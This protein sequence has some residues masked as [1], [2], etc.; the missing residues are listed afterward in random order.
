MKKY[1]VVILNYNTSHDAMHAAET[2]KNCAIISDYSICIVDNCSS[3]KEKKILKSRN[4][5]NTY[6]YFL[7]KNRGYAAGNNAGIKFM[8]SHERYKYIVIMNPDVEVI[9]NGTIESIIDLIEN[10]SN[11]VIGGQPLVWTQSLGGKKEEQ[12]NIR[13]VYSKWDC[14]IQGSYLLRHLLVKRTKD[15][16]YRGC[17]PYKKNMYY[18]V[19]SG[20][21]FIVNSDA[22]KQI[23]YFDEK[24]FLYFEEM[25]LGYKFKC[26]NQKFI[27]VPK[28]YVIHEQGKSTKSTARRV[29]KSSNKYDIESVSIYLEK[30]LN[31][32]K[33]FIKIYQ[34]ERRI[35]YFF[36]RIAYLIFDL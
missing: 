33:I 7:D 19:P 29:S 36:K 28:Y 24:T 13:R 35:D 23:G 14:F 6:I 16:A 22:F 32:S 26:K 20:A 25:I 34:L 1:L 8:T 10:D 31:A 11:M 15:L 27:F 12:V 17:V 18:E 21:F 4:L 5:E 9:E 30:Y 2:V 3:D